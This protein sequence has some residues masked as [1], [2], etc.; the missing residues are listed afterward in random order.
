MAIRHALKGAK[1]VSN[2]STTNAPPPATPAPVASVPTPAQI[3][4]RTLQSKIEEEVRA[5][6][7]A[8]AVHGHRQSAETMM[9]AAA[10]KATQDEIEARVAQAKVDAKT[11]LKAEVDKAAKAFAAAKA[12]YEKA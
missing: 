11:A 9:G 1:T 4:F 7:E 3:V 10:V 8:L 5:G 6:Q 12:A 2:E